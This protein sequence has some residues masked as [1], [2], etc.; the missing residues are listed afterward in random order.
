MTRKDLYY[1]ACEVISQ[2]TKKELGADGNTF[3]DLYFD[4]KGFIYTVVSEMKCG[5]LKGEELL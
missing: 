1:E 3:E 4:L 5:C 2:C